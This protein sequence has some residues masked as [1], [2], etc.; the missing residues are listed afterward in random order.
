MQ[1]S[2]NVPSA[3]RSAEYCAWPGSRAPTSLQVTRCTKALRSGPVISNSPMCDTSKMPTAS[4]TA[5]CSAAIPPPPPPPPV[6]PV[7]PLPPPPPPRVAHRHQ[8]APERHHLGAQAHVDVVQR[9]AP[10]GGA[11][12][13]RGGGGALGLLDH[14]RLGGVRPA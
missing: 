8:G 9:G 11:G 7:P 2:A 1:S 13:G 10:K 5:R 3:V 4:R 12:G 14:G 6:P